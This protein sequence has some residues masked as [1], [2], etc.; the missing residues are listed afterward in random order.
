MVLFT[1]Q[2]C[3][4]VRAPTTRTTSCSL[5]ILSMWVYLRFFPIDDKFPAGDPAGTPKGFYCSSASA[6]RHVK[7]SSREK[8]LFPSPVFAWPT[9]THPLPSQP[10]LSWHWITL[11]GLLSLFLFTANRYLFGKPQQ[12]IAWLPTHQ[13]QAFFKDSSGM[14]FSKTLLIKASLPH[15]HQ[16]PPGAP[17]SPGQLYRIHRTCSAL[18]VELP[19]SALPQYLVHTSSQHLGMLLRTAFIRKHD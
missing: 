16:S 15:S 13:I 12:R 7:A 19:S 6:Y 9:P 14:S 4:P 11:G 5:F 3:L 18:P 10:H 2:N 17:Q 1:T 8:R